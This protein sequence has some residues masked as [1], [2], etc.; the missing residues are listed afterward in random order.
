M[1]TEERLTANEEAMRKRIQ[2]LSKGK[3]VRRSGSEKEKL[4][5]ILGEE[6]CVL[7]G[8]TPDNSMSDIQ[9]TLT[10]KL[11]ELIASFE[12]KVRLLDE[13]DCRDSIRVDLNIDDVRQVRRRSGKGV[14]REDFS[15]HL[16]KQLKAGD[17]ENLR[18]HF[19]KF[20]TYAAKKICKQYSALLE[21]AV[22]EAQIVHG[23]AGVAATNSRTHVQEDV[24]STSVEVAVFPEKAATE[25]LQ[26]PTANE[27]APIDQPV[28][29]DASLTLSEEPQRSEPD[30]PEPLPE[31]KEPARTFLIRQAFVSLVLAMTL[32]LTFLPWPNDTEETGEEWSG[33]TLNS[34]PKP[35]AKLPI[36]DAL[37]VHTYSV[38]GMNGTW[39]AAVSD[40][41]VDLVTKP[42]QGYNSIGVD[43]LP[44]D[45]QNSLEEHGYL[46]GELRIQFAINRLDD[47]KRD[48]EIIEIRP[49]DIKKQPMPTGGAFLMPPS[50]NN[51]WIGDAEFYM[52]APAMEA[53]YPADGADAGEPFFQAQR[54][55]LS[56]QGDGEAFNLAFFAFQGAY[57]F[58][59]A[60]DYEAGGSQ[61]RT[62]VV[63]E[64]G[65]ETFKLT[66]DPCPRATPAQERLYGYPSKAD[67]E[68]VQGIK[69]GE[70]WI[71]TELEL[72]GGESASVI[73]QGKP[74]QYTTD[75]TNC[76]RINS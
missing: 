41:K 22:A 19:D 5:D 71:P 14:R 48:I 7:W 18:K 27:P 6:L 53:V 67:L 72:A 29:S 33:D 64:N 66:A 36:G 32:P 13:S 2:E 42:L 28:Q 60:V 20:A 16:K 51:D 69:Y 37:N 58:K 43:K 45:F 25:S 74:G 62:Y 63:N 49:V 17:V 54:K 11:N 15:Q 23:P 65:R 61:Y 1:A 3:G 44:A 52:N 76:A 73:A 75:T 39:S 8:V 30:S 68:A 70:L 12:A 46:L 50:K 24:P 59:I 47:D 10:V 57:T 55:T 38:T 40:D 4:L 34:S 35:P 9:S 31:R 21:R 56:F 26:E